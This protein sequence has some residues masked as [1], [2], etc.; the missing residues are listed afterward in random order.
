ML[1]RLLSLSNKVEHQHSNN[2]HL[3]KLIGIMKWLPSM[4][5]KRIPG[6]TKKRLSGSEQKRPTERHEDEDLHENEEGKLSC[7]TCGTS[8]LICATRYQTLDTAYDNLESRCSKVEADHRNLLVTYRNLAVGYEDLEADHRSLTAEH[9]DLRAKYWDLKVQRDTEEGVYRANEQELTLLTLPGEIR[10]AIYEFSCLE[11]GRIVITRDLKPP[12]LLSTCRQIRSEATA[13]WYGQNEFEVTVWDCDA[14]LLNSFYRHQKRLGLL[15]LAPMPMHFKL[16]GFRKWS[17]LV[18]WCLDIYHY[19][20]TRFQDDPA[21]TDAFCVV[22]AA[23]HE[24]VQANRTISWEVCERALESLR[25][26]VFRLDRG[27]QD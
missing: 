26:V 13:I 5:W 3:L 1:D 21:R 18:R 7:R 22:I 25:L 12:P 27:W 11:E 10:T 23:A 6:S 17:N 19:R 16:G 8:R 4:I 2:T 9:R 15:D 20:G 14:S 24:I